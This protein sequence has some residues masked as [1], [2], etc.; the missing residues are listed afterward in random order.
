MLSRTAANLY[1][2]GRYVER[3]DATAR[4]LDMGARMTMLPGSATRQDWLSV[5]KAAGVPL[6]ESEEVGR[7][8]AVRILLLDE[9]GGSSV[10]SALT[11][12]RSNARAERTALTRQAWEALNDEWRALEKVPEAEASSSLPDY[13]EWAQKR[14]AAFRG[15]VETTMLRDDR[16]DFIKLGG[17][18]ER[19]AM[20]LRLLEVKYFALLPERDV[21]GGGRDFHQWNSLLF[22]ASALRAYHHVYRGDVTAWNVADLLVLNRSF[23]RSVA[24]CITE[25]ADTLG[26]LALRYNQRTE[27][28]NRAERLHARLADTD[29]DEVFADG[30]HEF[31]Q[32]TLKSVLDIHSATSLV[33][34]F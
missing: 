32:E 24:L 2:T 4:L 15:S 12:A 8:E 16:Y 5:L 23:P 31:V 27:A 9:E 25:A 29:M 21:V 17:A 28:Q 33:Y 19:A 30:L 20:A 34:G 22:A 14:A 10:R 13:L 3:A 1:W 26:R 6:T 7:R 11:L 18:L